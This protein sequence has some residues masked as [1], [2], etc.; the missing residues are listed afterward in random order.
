[1]DK[2]DAIAVVKTV[3]EA[4]NG[5]EEVE[6]MTIDKHVRSLFYEL[7]RE[8]FLKLRREEFKFDNEA[9]RQGAYRT[10]KEEPYNIYQKIPR[11]AWVI[12][13]YNT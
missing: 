8:H 7:H 12:R 1:M 9:I 13:S 6:D 2:E 10:F 5:K 4:F 11:K 3:E